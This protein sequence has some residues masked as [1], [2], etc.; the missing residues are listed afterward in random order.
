MPDRLL[1]TLTPSLRYQAACTVCAFTGARVIYQP[2][3]MD[4]GYHHMWLTG[5]DVQV[6]ERT[7]DERSDG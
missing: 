1:L 6:W 2:A 7:S 3:A 5:H 4:D